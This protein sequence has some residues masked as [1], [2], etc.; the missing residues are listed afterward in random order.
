MHALR[1]SVSIVDAGSVRV[2]HRVHTA[3]AFTSGTTWDAGAT[4]LHRFDYLPMPL[5]ST[6][7]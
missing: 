6:A 4:K 1:P 5:R 7:M 2:F 3:F